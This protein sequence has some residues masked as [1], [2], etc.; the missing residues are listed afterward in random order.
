MG[1]S[2]QPVT[3]DDE[4]RF[5]GEEV[6]GPSERRAEGANVCFARFFRWVPDAASAWKSASLARM[7]EV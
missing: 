3:P 7:T 1:N 5:S 4:P 2:I 6:P